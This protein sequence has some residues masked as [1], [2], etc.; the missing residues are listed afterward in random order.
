VFIRSFEEF[1]EQPS[2]CV[3]PDGK[4]GSLGEPDV[5][6][7]RGEQGGLMLVQQGFDWASS[8]WQA[9]GKSS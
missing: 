3:N 6:R 9:S 8:F 2:E 4:T 7:L 1:F 5:T